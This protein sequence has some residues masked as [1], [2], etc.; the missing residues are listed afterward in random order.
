MKKLTTLLISLMFTLILC[1]PAFGANT[2]VPGQKCIT[3]TGL[4]ADWDSTA[5]GY[6]QAL[7][8]W[9]VVFYPGATDD[10]MV[11]NDGGA[12]E[13]AFYESGVCADKYDARVL[14]FPPGT[15]VKP[16]IDTDDIDVTGAKVKIYFR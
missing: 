7:D 15:K 2:T 11:I 4:D 9:A 14:Y 6:P 13:D 8:I 10:S 5:N 12:D 3:I 16:Y 1:F